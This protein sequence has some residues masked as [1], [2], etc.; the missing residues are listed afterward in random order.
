MIEQ[1]KIADVCGFSPLVLSHSTQY[2]LFPCFYLPSTSS[3]RPTWHLG[4]GDSYSGSRTLNIQ[5]Q[6]ITFFKR[7]R[8]AP[9]IAASAIVSM[10]PSSRKLEPPQ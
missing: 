1:I 10:D 5:N 6:D 7:M 8:R 2:F 4:Q 9:K 3:L